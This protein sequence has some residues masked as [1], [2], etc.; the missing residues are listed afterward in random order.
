MIDELS[1]QTL[2][3]ISRHEALS[4]VMT[5][6]IIG[7]DE[8]QPF[9]SRP[10]QRPTVSE[11][12]RWRAAACSQQ[13]LLWGGGAIDLLSQALVNLP[14]LKTIDLRDFNSNTRY[15]DA[16]PGNQVPPWRSYGSSRYQQ[17]PHQEPW[18]LS[19]TSTMN[20]PDTVFMVVL[21]AVGRHST[22]V[23]N[24]EVILR[25][26]QICLQDDAFNIFAVP[27]SGV[28][29][30]VRG[31]TKLHLDLCFQA[32]PHPGLQFA[33]TVPLYDWFDPHTAYFR[34]FLALTPNLTWLRLNFS[35]YDNRTPIPHPS[36]LIEWLA[37]G[38][39]LPAPVDAP[40]DEVNPAPVTLPLQRLDLGHVTTTAATLRRLLKKF[41][42]L[43]HISMRNIRLSQ[44]A[45]APDSNQSEENDNGDCVWARLI[46]KLHVTNPKLKQVELR[47]IEET[48][49]HSG[50]TIVFR[51][52]NNLMQVTGFTSTRIVDTTTLERLADN[53]WTGSRWYKSQRNGESADEESMD[54]DSMNENPMDED[55]MDPDMDDEE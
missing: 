30:G 48:T 53:T 37:L 45:D 24:L 20:F 33:A 14:N 28:T 32:S 26:R 10:A 35:R 43:D 3:D 12:H 11:F 5:H 34:H 9:N 36:R 13:A 54:E 4:K 50:D 40:W 19:L 17:W 18:L 15:R 52:Q 16:T 22:T 25:N 46:R 6:L 8:L 21:T 44:P 2:V 27:D 41:A 47:A 1:L 7:L 51:N 42:D 38:P 55:S 23:Q 39:D 49:S 29:E 31:L